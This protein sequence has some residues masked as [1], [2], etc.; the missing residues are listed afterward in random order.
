MAQNTSFSF[1]L[2]NFSCPPPPLM[3]IGLLK[4]FSCKMVKK[5]IIEN[6]RKFNCY[7]KKVQKDNKDL[8]SDKRKLCAGRKYIFAL[9]RQV[10]QSWKTIR[11]S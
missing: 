11:K 9:R 3:C 4:T 7:H 1:N 2:N 10:E 5:Y 8:I 6:K